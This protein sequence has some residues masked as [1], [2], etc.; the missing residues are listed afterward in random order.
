MRRVQDAKPRKIL[1]MKTIPHT[2]SEIFLAPININL[3]FNG[4]RNTVQV[5]VKK[6]LKVLQLNYKLNG[7]INYS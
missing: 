1:D 4:R 7:I 5:H 6:S 2:K 3:F